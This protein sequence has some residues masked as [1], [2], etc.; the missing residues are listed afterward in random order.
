MIRITILVL[1]LGTSTV[2]AGDAFLSGIFKTLGGAIL[3]GAASGLSKRI[4]GQIQGKKGLY[5][6]GTGG[7]Q[8]VQH[9]YD[10]ALQHSSQQAS[11]GQSRSFLDFQAAQADADRINR[12]WLQSQ[13]HKHEKEMARMAL[14]Y[15]GDTSNGQT[16]SL[17]N[18]PSFLA[19]TRDPGRTGIDYDRAPVYFNP[20]GR[21]NI[22]PDLLNWAK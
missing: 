6:S 12:E 5:A 10:Q 15:N 17:L 18:P 20:Y 11:Q 19:P 22:D 4:E 13:Q 9:R 1:L 7:A 16:G 8:A 21:E 3:G 14:S 2:T